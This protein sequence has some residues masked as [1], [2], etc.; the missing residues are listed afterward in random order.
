MSDDRIV[1][2]RVTKAH[3][4]KGEVVVKPLTD[5]TERFAVGAEVLLDGA[6]T[7]IA[8]ARP[9]QGRQL[10][11]F[12]G[13]TDRDEAELL[14]GRELAVVRGDLDDAE[15]F[16]AHELVGMTVADE[17]GNVLGEVTDLIEI[18][19]L[20]GYDLLE[21][22]GE[23][24]DTWLLPDSDD[25]VVVAVDPTDETSYLMVV[26]PPEGLLPGT[27]AVVAAPDVED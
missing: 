10:L 8:T 3:G 24:G 2:G 6:P 21:V 16:F 1:I 17:D 13:V 25:L 23:D 4:L 12:E 9:H 15:Y 18:P 26:D 22:T 5:L 19:A 11:R 20:A 27:E 14:R 7:T